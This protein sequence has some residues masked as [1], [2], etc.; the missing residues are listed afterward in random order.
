MKALRARKVQPLIRLRHIPS[1]LIAWR[2]EAGAAA[3]DASAD[4]KKR[5]HA[6]RFLGGDRIA[7]PVLPPA[8]G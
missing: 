4:R 2:I 5:L 6:R 1:H 8:G 7:R 3:G